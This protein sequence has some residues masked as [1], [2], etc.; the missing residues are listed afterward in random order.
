M[1]GSLQDDARRTYNPATHSYLQSHVYAHDVSIV[2]TY[3][4]GKAHF[5]CCYDS[6]GT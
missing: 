2:A 1:N 6:A 3:A 4:H 5:N